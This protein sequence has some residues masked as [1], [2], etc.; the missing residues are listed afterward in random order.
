MPPK[1]FDRSR[2]AVQKIAT[3]VQVQTNIP[4]LKRQF[5]CTSKRKVMLPEQEKNPRGRRG[6]F[7]T[8][9]ESEEG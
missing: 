4:T 5:I 3:A 8:Q 1:Q 2:R 7:T 6:V 9:L